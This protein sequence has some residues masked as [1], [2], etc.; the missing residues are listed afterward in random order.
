MLITYKTQ[1]PSVLIEDLGMQFANEKS[2]VKRRFGLFKCQCGK[3]FKANYDRVIRSG[4]GCGCLKIKHGQKD[5]KLYGVWE[6]IIQRT[7]NPKDKSYCKYGGRGIYMCDEWR[8]DFIA[9]HNWSILNGYTQGLSIDRIDNNDGYY[10]NNC[11]WATDLVQ[12][13]NTRKIR[14]NNTSGF[15]GVVRHSKVSKWMAQIQIDNKHKYLGLFI[16][17]VEAA[18]AYDTYIIENNLPHTRNFNTMT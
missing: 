4:N 1:S 13:A 12:A 5:S 6:G 16:T 3:E 18:I 2:K 11:R 7:S 8:N 14:S 9:F 17:A 10:P 15:R